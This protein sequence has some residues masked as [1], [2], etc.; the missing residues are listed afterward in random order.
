MPRSTLLA[1]V[2]CTATLVPS[3]GAGAQ[4]S[5]ETPAELEG[6]EIV[7][8]SGEQLPAGLALVD[9]SGEPVVLGDY[10]D[11]GKPILVQLVYYDCPMLC[12]LVMNGY[13]EGAK[14]LDWV[15]GAD[16]E[17]LAVSF[18]PRDKPA[19]AKEKKK[20]YVRALGKPEAADGWHFLTGEEPQVRTLAD[21]LGFKYRWLEEKGEFAHAAGIFVLTPDGTISRTLYGI[22]FAE[23]DLRLSLV[24]ASEGRLGSPF[25]KLLLYCFQYDS[26]T[27][28]YAL[29]AVNVMKLG[30]LLMVIA[31]GTFLVVQWTRERRLHRPRPAA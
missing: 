10:L 16:Y 25:D 18:D 12:S 26:E 23:K 21:A 14:G 31:I 17:V 4:I 20:N 5:G 3:P 9:E 27:H 7:D 24:E 15:P 1:I 19:V 28:K 2:V 6:I 30:G 22:Q 13:V 8:R 29:V 11:R